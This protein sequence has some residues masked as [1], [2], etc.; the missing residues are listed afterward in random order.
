MKES[1]KLVVAMMI[2]YYLKKSY[3][4]STTNLP[5]DIIVSTLDN[6]DEESL[7]PKAFTEES[8]EDF[9]MMRWMPDDLYPIGAKNCDVSLGQFTT[10][11]DGRSVLDASSNFNM[12]WIDFLYATIMNREDICK[13]VH[14]IL[15]VEPQQQNEVEDKPSANGY[16]VYRL[17]ENAIEIALI[18]FEK[19]YKHGDCPRDVVIS[20]I[21]KWA[22]EAEE[23]WQKG[24]H[25]YDYLKFI[26]DFTNPKIEEFLKEQ[27]ESSK[28]NDLIREIAQK[29]ALE[30][31]DEG[32]DRCTYEEV[33]D[34]IRMGIKN[35][36]EVS[37]N[38]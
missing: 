11:M 33:A 6:Y 21:Q 13:E 9:V 23:K 37:K 19:L 7:F 31:T 14:N 28:Q 32:Y 8:F 24:E 16:E 4:N 29:Y 30:Y 2:G 22:G 35:Y 34:A 20:T 25:D 26:E 38:N 27:E 17:E 12:S 1:M 3:S 5:Y 10:F 18:C 15:V 36:I